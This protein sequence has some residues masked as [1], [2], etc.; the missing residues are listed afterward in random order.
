[1]QFFTDISTTL[2]V[3][4]LVIAHLIC[5]KQWLLYKKSK[6]P[7]VNAQAKVLHSLFCAIFSLEYFLYIVWWYL[8][9]K[10]KQNLP[11]CVRC[12]CIFL[13]NQTPIP[14]QS[15]SLSSELPVPPVQYFWLY[16]KL[17]LQHFYILLF[18]RNTSILF[19]PK[20]SIHFWDKGLSALSI[21]SS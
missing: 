1:M 8:S 4:C 21:V 19:S 5:S 11:I 9:L 2:V 15:P 6:H 18:H 10:K 17:C 12:R 7:P 13:F 16:W 3:S 14:S 20:Y